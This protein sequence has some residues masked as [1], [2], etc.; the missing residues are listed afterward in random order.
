MENKVYI[1][2]LNYNNWADTIACAESLLLGDYDNFRLIIVDNDSPDNSMHYIRLWA[3]GRLSSWTPPRDP[4]HELSSPAVQKP[5][6]FVYYEDDAYV[7][8]C[9]GDHKVV[10][11]Q[12][13]Q[14][15]GYSA[16][17]NIGIRYAKSRGDFDYIWILNNDTVVRRDTLTRLVAFAAENSH[18][19]LI[20][21]TLLFY[22]LPDKIQAFGASFNPRLAV[23]KHYLAHAPYSRSLVSQFDQKQLDYI[24]GASMFMSRKCID[25]IEWMPE[26]Y[27]IYF[28]EIDIATNCRRKGLDFAICTEAIVYHKESVSI[29]QENRK[30]SAF[31]DFYAM[32]NRL[33]V[34]RK[35]YPRFLPSVYLGLGLSMLLRLGRRE[36]QSAGNIIKI[37]RTPL[38]RIEGLQYRKD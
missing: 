20:G 9:S 4:L 22:D 32:R 7:R 33:I 18:L 36:F 38:S 17:N 1:V 14:N 34:T 30:T 8:E 13:G 19:G 29:K 35:Y 25:A 2:V 11:L 24:I 6:D 27:F 37:M 31:S 16:G 21:T 3:E 12:S 23:Q 28:E 10:L 5:V 26:E 15:R